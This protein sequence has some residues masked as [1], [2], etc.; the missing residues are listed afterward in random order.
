M[1]KC[2]FLFPAQLK[3][4][5]VFIH[6]GKKES[7]PFKFFSGIIY[8]IFLPCISNVAAGCQ[9]ADML[10]LYDQCW[11]HFGLSFH[12]WHN[13]LWLK[14]KVERNSLFLSTNAPCSSTSGSNLFLELP[15]FLYSGKF[16][17][18]PISQRHK[19]ISIVP[20][21]HYQNTAL[22]LGLSFLHSLRVIIVCVLQ[23]PPHP[24]L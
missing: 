11:L 23:Y 15:S 21:Y 6:K 19:I 1:T 17:Q 8:L 14:P 13:F 16:I 3:W 9:G 4:I 10:R 22:Y 18:P 5:K 7:L 20:S 12:F 2:L 24:A